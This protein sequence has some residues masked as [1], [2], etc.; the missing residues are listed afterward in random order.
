MEKKYIVAFD[1]GTNSTRAII[2][3]KKGTIIAISPKKM[4]HYYPQPS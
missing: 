1:Q 2:F 4:K 3:D